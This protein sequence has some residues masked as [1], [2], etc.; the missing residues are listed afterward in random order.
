MDRDRIVQVL[1]NLIGNAIKFI[2]IGGQIDVMLEDGDD[3]VTIRVQDD[4]PGMT[5]E[6]MA[7][8][9]DRFVQAKI[10]KGPGQHGTGLGLTISRELVKMHGGQIWVESEIGK[11]SVF[12]FSLPKQP[13]SGHTQP[14][15]E[16]ANKKLLTKLLRKYKPKTRIFCTTASHVATIDV[17]FTGYHWSV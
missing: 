17:D 6:D 11:G 13:H 2:P 8:I 5:P 7:R 1:V 12:S 9:F 10:L 15:S 16:I 14:A 4:G 3:Q